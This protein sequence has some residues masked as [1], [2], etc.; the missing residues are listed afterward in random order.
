MRM[1]R[2]V[3]VLR[4]TPPAD[5]VL[6]TAVCS[7]GYFKLAP[8]RWDEASQ[9]YHTIVR[10]GDEQL[11]NVAVTQP[12][13][14]LRV[15]CRPGVWRTDAVNVR[16][17]LSRILRLDEDFS[18]FHKRHAGAKRAGFGRLI[19]SA[20][21][22]EDIVKTMTV[23]NVAW[24][25]SVRMNELLCEHFGDGGFPTPSQLAGSRA[26]AVKRKCKVGYRAAWIVRLARD[27]AAGK[28]D[29]AWFEDTQRDGDESF[30][31]LRIIHGVGPYA[32]NNIC[33]LLGHYDRLAIDT[34]TY[35][36]FKQVHQVD[37]AGRDAELHRRIE[38]HYEKYRPY[39]Y[40]AYWYELWHGYGDRF[41]A[42][43]T[44]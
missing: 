12:S 11:I 23:C 27:V 25:N 9:A 32:A 34:E 29:V 6:K 37:T 15:T 3:S 36:H 14:A 42:E 22:F 35:R 43:D 28:F 39:Q 10:S 8:N 19:R 30:D 5:L 18:A 2:D 21:L 41:V 33:M 20:T 40:L 16:R 4:I 24:A 31:R 13:Q 1:P 38:R 7:Y 17:Q 26:D 44:R